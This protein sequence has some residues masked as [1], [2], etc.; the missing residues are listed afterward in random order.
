MITGLEIDLVVSDSLAAIK[1]YQEIFDIEIIEQTNYDRGL[2]EVIFTLY[3]VRLHLM[4]E[5]PDYQLFAPKKEDPKS[6]W[7]NV[8]VPDIK[9]TFNKALESGATAVQEIVQMP[10]MGLSNAMVMDNFNYI[11]M[12]HQIDRVISPE[13]K[14]A[15]F[16]KEFG[17]EKD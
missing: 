16:E 9:Q 8:V 17:P 7:F 13:E 5:N 4:D 3:G 14:E 11:W 12:L 2:N 10:E 6:I 1:Q 15:F